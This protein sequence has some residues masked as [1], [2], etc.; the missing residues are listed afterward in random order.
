MCPASKSRHICRV[1]K[2]TKIN[3]KLAKI[4][5]RF[6]FVFG[7]KIL[8]ETRPTRYVKMEKVRGGLKRKIYPANT[9]PKRGV[10]FTV[11]LPIAPVHTKT[12]F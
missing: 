1:F 12:T 9:V 6:S 11:W 8:R 5:L 3:V 2:I 7:F 10:G 4:L